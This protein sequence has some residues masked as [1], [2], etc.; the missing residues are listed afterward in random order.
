MSPQDQ[1]TLHLS[2]QFERD[3]Y[4]MMKKFFDN[5]LIYESPHF[6]DLLNDLDKVYKPTKPMTNLTTIFV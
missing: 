6:Q 5:K 4:N 3:L 1:T 2:C